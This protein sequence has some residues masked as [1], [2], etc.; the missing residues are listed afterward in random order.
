MLGTWLRQLLSSARRCV[1]ARF[2]TLHVLFLFESRY[3]SWLVSTVHARSSVLL[4]S[5]PGSI[6]VSVGWLC[7]DHCG[8]EDVP[9]ACHELLQHAGRRKLPNPRVVSRAPPVAGDL[10]SGAG[11]SLPSCPR[12]GSDRTRSVC[13]MSYEYFGVI[14]SIPSVRCE[15]LMTY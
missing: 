1:V 12:S 10:T 15:I 8:R 6:D 7:R 11:E 3:I 14:K 2:V 9:H 5:P 4:V 13:T